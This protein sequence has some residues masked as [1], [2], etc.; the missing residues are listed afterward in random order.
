[1]PGADEVSARATLT[2]ED[3]RRDYGE[4]GRFDK[5]MVRRGRPRVHRPRVS[6]TIRLSQDVSITQGR[7]ARLADSDQRRASR[8]D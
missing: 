3:D 2:V 8:V 5:A 6:T 4:A 7:W 1:M